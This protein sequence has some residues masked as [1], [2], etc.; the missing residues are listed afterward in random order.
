MRVFIARDKVEAPFIRCVGLLA[1][2]HVLVI[3]YNVCM[4]IHVYC[5]SYS[6]GAGS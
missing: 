1:W 3:V 5:I 6:S 4:D 2:F